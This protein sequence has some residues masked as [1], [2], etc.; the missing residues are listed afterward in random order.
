MSTKPPRNNLSSGRADTLNVGLLENSTKF[1]NTSDFNNL[2]NETIHRRKN[3]KFIISNFLKGIGYSPLKMGI[4]NLSLN[5]N[6]SL[7]N[8]HNTTLKT[9]DRLSSCNNNV[10]TSNEINYV[11]FLSN[12]LI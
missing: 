12:I 7:T 4:K 2:A 6:S 8:L 9:V 1:C 11:S 5:A 3:A 10:A